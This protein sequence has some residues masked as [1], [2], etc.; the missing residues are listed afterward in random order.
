ML[1]KAAGLELGESGGVKCSAT[2]ETSVPGIFAAGDAAEWDSPLHG[3][4]A[5]VEHFEVAKAHGA[6]AAHNMLGRGRPHDEVPYFWTDLSDWAGFEYV[7]IGAGS[8]VVVRG[9]L[10]DGDFTAFYLDARRVVG[11]L[12]SG[13]SDDLDAARR[14]IAE[15]TKA[16]PAKLGDESADLAGL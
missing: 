4:S 8:D 15:R 2:L 3:S 13:R 16:D 7:G 12:T 9:S 11:A 5:R 6:T 10:D 1:A 14:F